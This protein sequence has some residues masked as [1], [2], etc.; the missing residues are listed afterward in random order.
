MKNFEKRQKEISWQDQ[1]QES[2][3]T[4]ETLAETL[5]IMLS[6]FMSI[7]SYFIYL[8]HVIV[9]R[10]TDSCVSIQKSE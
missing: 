2:H 8:Y 4:G 3:S 7:G 9:Q 6:L 10:G 5:T 1:A